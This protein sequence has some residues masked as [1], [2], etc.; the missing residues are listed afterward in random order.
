MARTVPF[1]PWWNR[2][3]SSSI[4]LVVKL[5]E[6]CDEFLIVRCKLIEQL[7][8]GRVA[9][10]GRHVLQIERVKINALWQCLHQSHSCATRVGVDMDTVHQALG[11]KNAHAHTARGL[12]G[13]GEN[14]RQIAN[15]RTSATRQDDETLGNPA[16]SSGS[17]LSKQK[18]RRSSGPSVRKG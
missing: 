7:G 11:A 16:V 17:T 9:D 14:G 15:P 18:F 2:Q 1:T 6:G 13:P 4:R 8:L 3:R 12:I 5:V 10:R